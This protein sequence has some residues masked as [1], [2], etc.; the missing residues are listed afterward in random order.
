MAKLIGVIDA[1]GN[2]EYPELSISGRP[3]RMPPITM[4]VPGG[5]VVMDANPVPN[6]DYPAAIRALGGTYQIGSEDEVPLTKDEALALAAGRG[7]S[8]TTRTSRE[9]ALGFL[10]GK[11]VSAEVAPEA[12]AEEAPSKA[13]NK[14]LA[15]ITDKDAA[16]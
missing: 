10:D 15:P 9:A 8:V 16:K 14:P 3:Y 6:F 4:N 11:P 5:F 1:N 12:V 2:P 13:A 7:M